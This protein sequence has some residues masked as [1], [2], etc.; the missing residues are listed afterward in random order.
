MAERSR[1]GFGWLLLA[2]AAPMF[3]VSLNNLVV[4]NAL[5]VMSRDLG[6][7]PSG[8]QWV[9]HAYALAFAG[10]LLTGAALGDRFGRRRVFLVA[11]GVFTAGS[12]ACALA[13]SLPALLAARVVQGAGAAAVYPVSL[14]LLA[15]GVPDRRRT[16]AVGLWSAVNGLGIALGPLAG[17]LVAVRLSWPWIFWLLVPIGLALVPLCRWRLAESRGDDGAL[18]L[19]GMVLVSLSVALAVLGT[20]RAGQDG[21]TAPSVLAPF[22]GAV[23]GGIAFVLW[24]R[25]CPHPLLPLRFYRVPAFVL[26][27]AVSFTMFF[28]VFGSIYW[29]MLYLQGPVGYS[30]LEAGVRTLP[31][32]AMPMLV[33]VAAGVLANRVRPGALIAAGLACEAL[34]LAASAVLLRPEF[35]YRLVL[36]AL[37]L[38]GIGMGLVFTPMTAA[39]LASVRPAERGKA[40]GANTTVR[41]IGFALGVAVMTTVV[42]RASDGRGGLADPVAFVEAVRPAV[43]VGAAVV[44]VGA[45]AAAFLRVPSGT[46]GDGAAAVVVGRAVGD[47]AVRVGDLR[48]KD[49]VG[50]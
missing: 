34:A 18:D 48:E 46:T 40:S 23:V 49:E 26:S 42:L 9:V 1:G 4:T 2:T 32:T 15:T 3:L 19:P 35:D 25:R 21:W 41:E 37:L 43:W 38:G 33:A 24:E 20:A 7:G 30:A 12:A 16:V 13:D 47:T 14:T 8:S 10:L 44:L 28:G 22:A 27:N 5:P 29:L 45:V 11:I 6:I 31:W 39:V 50:R 17:G 36:P